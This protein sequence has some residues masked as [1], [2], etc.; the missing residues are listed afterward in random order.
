VISA[1][2][3]RFISLV[4]RRRSTVVLKRA[5][6]DEIVI[7]SQ[8]RAVPHKSIDSITQERDRSR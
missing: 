3:L 5:K 6:H 7:V 1:R 2:W 4:G 8:R